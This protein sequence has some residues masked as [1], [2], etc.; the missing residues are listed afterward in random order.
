MRKGVWGGFLCLGLVVGGVGFAVASSAFARGAPQIQTLHVDEVVPSDVCDGFGTFGGFPVQNHNV[1]T[2]RIF[3]Y[4]DGKRVIED[5]GRTTSTNLDTGRSISFAFS[6]KLTDTRFEELFG[7][8]ASR[9]TLTTTFTGLNFRILKPNAFSLA[10]GRGTVTATYTFDEDGNLVDLQIVELST[11]HLRHFFPVLCSLLGSERGSISGTVTDQATKKPVANVCVFAADRSG[12][13][14]SFGSSAADGTYHV[15]GLAAGAYRLLFT[16]ADCVESPLYAPEWWRDKLDLASADAVTVKTDAETKRINPALAV[17][18]SITGRVTNAAGGAPLESICVAAFAPGSGPETPAVGGALTAPDGTYRISGLLGGF[19]QVS[20]GDCFAGVYAPEWYDDAPNRSSADPVAVILGS[21]TSNVNAALAVGGKVTGTVTSIDSGSPLEGVCVFASD[22]DVPPGES[23]GV[24]F[25]VTGRDGRYELGGLQGGNVKILFFDCSVGGT[26]SKWY[27]DKPDF[28][29]ADRVQVALGGT[30]SG[31]DGALAGVG[32]RVSGVVTDAATGAPVAGV[33]VWLLNAISGRGLAL[34]ATE[35]DG[36]YVVGL[37]EHV[38]P[39]RYKVQFDTSERGCGGGAPFRSEFY[40]NKVRWQSADLVTVAL[41]LDTSGINASLGDHPSDVGDIRGTVIDGRTGAP[42]SDVCVSAFEPGSREFVNI[43]ETGPDGTYDIHELPLGSYTVSFQ[44]CADRGYVREWYENKPTRGSADLVSV[45]GGSDATGIDAALVIGGTI[46]GVVSAQATGQPIAGACVTAG[47]GDGADFAVTGIDGTYQ[48]R[49][50]AAG[51]YRVRFDPGCFSASVYAPEWYDKKSSAL[52]ADPVSVALGAQTSGINAAL[53]I[54]GSITGKVTAAATN[55]PLAEVCVAF[56]DV[57]TGSLYEQAIV[58]GPDGSYRVTGL[59]PGGYKLQF[60]GDS[61]GNCS[62]GMY[63]PEWFDGKA[64]RA[65]A[66]IV[67]VN[68]LGAETAGVDV[69]LEIG[70]TVSGT[71]TGADTGEL[72]RDICVDITD[73]AEGRHGGSALTGTDGTYEVT[74]L[75]TG[76]YV[77][78]FSDCLLTYG[79]AGGATEWYMNK[80][81]SASAD[82]VN[83]TVGTSLTG[84]DT[85]LPGL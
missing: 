64:D 50:L 74:G 42:L 48:V 62:V 6:L 71:V 22:A 43:E 84:I 4:P 1:E 56:V 30:T 9:V 13:F 29:S 80:P 70:G 67:S 69:Q 14:V 79:H 31:I 54:G 53:S 16:Q 66:D 78:R 63:A 60:G 45:A 46:G 17:G 36:T 35:S 83:V 75:A 41:G 85:A 25:A 55:Q 65:S 77:V 82:R 33:C 10:A 28:S 52:A 57:G 51:S 12:T 3:T 27:D 49:G 40:D 76:S 23:G 73:P 15:L 7:N 5:T 20:F 59:A 11:P 44:D 34:D 72:L 21:T 37:F 61:G 32:G 39:G 26:A 68:A 24:G 19:Y 2:I 18:G 8:G 38:P 58:T 81:D 47:V